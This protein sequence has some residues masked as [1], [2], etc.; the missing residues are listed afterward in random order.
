[1]YRAMYN[2]LTDA[3]KRLRNRLRSYIHIDICISLEQIQW[4]TVQGKKERSCIKSSFTG[5]LV[6]FS[7]RDETIMRRAH[8]V[9]LPEKRYDRFNSRARGLIRNLNFARVRDYS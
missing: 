4:V 3:Q 9:Q 2:R 8:V 7:L 6:T 5:A 1:M